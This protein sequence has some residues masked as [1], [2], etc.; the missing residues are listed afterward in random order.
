MVP[1]ANPWGALRSRGNKCSAMSPNSTIEK[2]QRR[3]RLLDAGCLPNLQRFQGARADHMRVESSSCCFPSEFVSFD[4][5]VT[6]SPPMGK[7]I[8]FDH[9]ILQNFTSA[10]T[11]DQPCSERAAKLSLKLILSGEKEKKSSFFPC[12]PRSG[13]ISLTEESYV[14]L[15]VAKVFTSS[16]TCVFFWKDYRNLLSFTSSIA[17]TQ[18]L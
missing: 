11:R 13:L 6:H 7:R 5:H 3:N 14:L 8:L 1:E 12:I 17:Q 2:Q 4:R 18:V 16:V 10:A 15:H 9:S